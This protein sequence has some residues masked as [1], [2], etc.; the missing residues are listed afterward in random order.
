MRT[1]TCGRLTRL[2]IV[3]LALGA[4]S[5]ALTAQ[6]RIDFSGFDQFWRIVDILRRNVEPTEQQWHALLDAPAYR[7]AEVNLGPVMRDAID[8]AFKPS[9]HADRERVAA[10]MSGESM[11]VEHLLRAAAQRPD[12]LAFRD[13]LA[14]SSVLAEAVAIAARYL[15]AGAT[16]IGPPPPVA[17]ALFLDDGYSLPGGIV[18]DLLN[19]RRLAL[20][21]NL[22]HE[23]HH[24]YVNRLARPLPPNSDA[25]PEAGLRMALYDLR[26]EGLADLIDKP[27]PFKSPN[28]GL[29]DYVTHYNQEYGNTPSRIHTLDSLLSRVADDSTELPAASRRAMNLFWSNGHPNGA[30]MAREIYQT[31]GID[32]LRPAALDPAAFLRL[33]A[34]AERVHQ[35][36]APFS[37]KARRVIELLDA[38]YWRPMPRG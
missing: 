29:A 26:N 33:Y 8:V 6:A 21:T 1:T 4:I 38:R 37:A 28:P 11:I 16:R 15:P 10:G 18:I 34:E 35:R 27:F 5:P 24:S 25:A 7:L 32:S 20:A 12:L 17:A 2:L 14:R 36:P 3:A 22:A 13:S 31:F 23:F 19:V 9:R 30:C